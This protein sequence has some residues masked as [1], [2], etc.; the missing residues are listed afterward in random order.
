[1][2]Q[3]NDNNLRKKGP[4]QCNYPEQDMLGQEADGSGLTGKVRVQVEMG[5]VFKQP[6]CFG[7]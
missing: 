3:K 2:E 6:Y 4:L 5:H 7:P 1:M